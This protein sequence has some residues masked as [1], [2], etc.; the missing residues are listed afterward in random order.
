MLWSK[1]SRDLNSLYFIQVKS[2]LFELTLLFKG[3]PTQ[4][5]IKIDT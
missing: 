2:L 1:D 3:K 5:L 4:F